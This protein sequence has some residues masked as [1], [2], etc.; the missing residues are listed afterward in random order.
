MVNDNDCVFQSLA[1]YSSS[2]LFVC[3]T[4]SQVAMVVWP[5]AILLAGLLPVDAD[6][7][8]QRIPD[9]D[10]PRVSLIQIHLGRGP[11]QPPVCTSTAEARVITW[12][13]LQPWQQCAQHN[14]I[15]VD[16]ARRTLG[17]VYLKLNLS[18]VQVR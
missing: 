17:S 15:I 5:S 12:R 1:H 7:S 6:S 13:E 8:T 4:L 16:L 10:D 11:T 9:I 18:I 14:R 3:V 2:F